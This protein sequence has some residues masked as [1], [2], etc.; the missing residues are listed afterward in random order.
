MKLK[1]KIHE[2]KEKLNYEK[3]IKSSDNGYIV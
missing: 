1:Q 2:T 3:S